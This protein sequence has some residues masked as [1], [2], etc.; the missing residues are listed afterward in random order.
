MP[1][2]LVKARG[3]QSRAAGAQVFGKDADEFFHA[4]AVAKYIGE[5]AAAGKKEYALPD[6][7]ERRAARSVSSRARRA[8]MPAAGPRTT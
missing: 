6:V 2:A 1:A 7:R 5:V 8:A 4:W 3:V